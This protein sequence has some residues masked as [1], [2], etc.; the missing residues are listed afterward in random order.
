MSTKSN[1][2]DELDKFLQFVSNL[3]KKKKK[4]KDLKSLKRHISRH[5]LLFYYIWKN[6][7]KNIT[8]LKLQH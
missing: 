8:T 5:D 4:K 3:Q 7:N 1:K 6:I 2:A